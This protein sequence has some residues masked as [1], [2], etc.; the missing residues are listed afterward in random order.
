MNAFHTKNTHA[1]FQVITVAKERFIFDLAGR[2]GKTAQGWELARHRV[3]TIGS[4]VAAGWVS[5]DRPEDTE[6][7]HYTYTLTPRG[8]LISGESV[9]SVDP[10]FKD[11]AYQRSRCQTCNRTIVREVLRWVHLMPGNDHDPVPTEGVRW[12]ASI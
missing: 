8:R 10:T 1:G 9:D 2:D 11:E 4:C 12:G 3:P 6:P 7:S 5:V